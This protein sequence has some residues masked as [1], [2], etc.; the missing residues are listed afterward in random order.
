MNPSWELVFLPQRGDRGRPSIAGNSMQGS[1]HWSKYR[2]KKLHGG[3]G[4]V[5]WF[6]YVSTYF[7]SPIYFRLASLMRAGGIAQRMIVQRAFKLPKFIKFPP[8][9]EQASP[10]TGKKQ[11]THPHVSDDQH[12]QPL[13]LST[14]DLSTTIPTSS[15]PSWYHQQRKEVIQPQVPLRLP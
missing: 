13:T 2:H 6:S 14:T 7:V 5:S 12:N 11:P 1:S 4:S 10:L 15:L 9:E 8:K 3:A